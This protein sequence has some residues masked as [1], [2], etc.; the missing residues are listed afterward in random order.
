MHVGARLHSGQ[1]GRDGG[2]DVAVVG[3]SLAMIAHG[4]TSTIPATMDMMLILV[5]KDKHQ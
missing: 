5:E 3:D 4:R 2:V 1:V